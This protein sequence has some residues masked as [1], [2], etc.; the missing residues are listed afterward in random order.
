MIGVGP[1]RYSGA[2]EKQHNGENVLR[3]L[4]AAGSASGRGILRRGPLS[5]H[6]H[7]T[8]SGSDAGSR[9][10]RGTETSH[11]TQSARRTIGCFAVRKQCWKLGRLL[12]LLRSNR[13]CYLVNFSFPWVVFQDPFHP[14]TKHF[15][16]MC[17]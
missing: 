9:P 12:A 17:K 14:R 5:R 3:V 11:G 10:S 7:R 1:M 2:V 8:G 13:F 15:I 16:Y 4:L 6:F